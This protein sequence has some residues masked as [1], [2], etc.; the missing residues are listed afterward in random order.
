M[1]TGSGTQSA[2]WRR[3]P[4]MDF[5]EVFLFI[6][7]GRGTASTIAPHAGRPQVLDKALLA[8]ILAPMIKL[9]AIFIFEVSHGY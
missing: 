7:Y 4:R 2:G 3:P 5:S 1:I 9:S 8:C 6:L